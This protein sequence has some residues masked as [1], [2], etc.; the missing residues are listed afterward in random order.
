MDRDSAIS[1][2]G[3]KTAKEIVENELVKTTDAYKTTI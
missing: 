2:A 3:A 1:T